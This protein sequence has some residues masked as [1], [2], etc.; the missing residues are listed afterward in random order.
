MGFKSTALW[1]V[2]GT[3]VQRV[4]TLGSSANALSGWIKGEDVSHSAHESV[5]KGVFKTLGEWECD[6]KVV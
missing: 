3:V 2:L 6:P 1:F 5:S 4:Q